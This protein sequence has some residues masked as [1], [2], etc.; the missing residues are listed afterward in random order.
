MYVDSLW[1]SLI[2]YYIWR[3][4]GSYSGIE[5]TRFKMHIPKC[6]IV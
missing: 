3:V 1:I 4:P 2:L 5:S 6:Y